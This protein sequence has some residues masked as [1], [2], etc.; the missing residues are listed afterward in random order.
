MQFG[1]A[2]DAGAP[3]QQ[4]LATTTETGQRVRQDT[5]DTDDELGVEDALVDDDGHP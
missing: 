2:Q 5:A 4:D 3:W 1:D